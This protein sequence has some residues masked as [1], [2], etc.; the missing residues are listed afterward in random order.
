MKRSCEKTNKK[1]GGLSNFRLLKMMFLFR[2]VYYSKMCSSI[3]LE[4]I[5]KIN[6]V[7]VCMCV[8]CTWVIMKR[9]IKNLIMRYDFRNLQKIHENGL[10]IKLRIFVSN[11]CCLKQFILNYESKYLM[12]S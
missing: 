2:R 5:I 3:A 6:I 9:T 11:I 8:S 1:P 12:I 7:K 4:C 10:S